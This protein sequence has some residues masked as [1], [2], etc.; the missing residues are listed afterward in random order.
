MAAPLAVAAKAALKKLAIASVTDKRTGKTVLG[1]IGGVVFALVA[2]VLALLAIL[3][4][5]A[6]LDLAALVAQANHAQLAYFEGIMLAIEDEILAQ[7]LD[8]DPLRAQIIFLSALQHHPRDGDFF[9]RFVASFADGQDEFS[10]IA[11]AFG[12][13]FSPE[14]ISQM[15]QLIAWAHQSQTGA[16]N[17]LHN[18]ILAMTADDDTPF[19]GVFLSPLRDRAWRPLLTSGFGYRTHP[20]SGERRFHNGIDLALPMGTRL[21]AAAA[22][23]VL[24]VGYDPRGFG[25]FVVLWHGGGYA[26]LYAHN[27]RNLVAEGQPVC[28]D[29]VIALSG[30]SGSSTGPHLHFEVIRDGRPVNPARYLPR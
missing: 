25:H 8:V 1:I 27:D 18:R 2:P 10:A 7:N 5:G 23:R 30:N 28:V 21:Y 20:I 26:T 15:E 13:R 12:V 17:N 11:D 16:P 19:E 29:T 3:Q 4:G 24:I 14:E 6:D 9:A 22:G